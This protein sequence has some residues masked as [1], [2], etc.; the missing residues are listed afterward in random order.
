MKRKKPGLGHE[1]L[2]PG[3]VFVGL[4]LSTVRIASPIDT[5]G[6]HAVPDEENQ[7]SHSAIGPPALRI[8]CEQPDS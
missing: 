1:C 8:S 7:S 2:N 6:H 3:C 4:C 5:D